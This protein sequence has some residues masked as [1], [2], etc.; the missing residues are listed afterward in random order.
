MTKHLLLGTI[1]QDPIRRVNIIILLSSAK[2]KNK[3]RIH[4]PLDNWCLTLRTTAS[5]LAY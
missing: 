4:Q 1:K 3:E 2:L 5:N